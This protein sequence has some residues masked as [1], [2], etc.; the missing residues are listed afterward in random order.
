MAETSGFLPAISEAMRMAERQAEQS[1]M[2]LVRAGKL[3]LSDITPVRTDAPRQ[4]EFRPA[5]VASEP[6]QE[7]VEGGRGTQRMVRFDE[8]S[9]P[10]QEEQRQETPD[11]VPADRGTEMVTNFEKAA[12]REKPASGPEFDI[13]FEEAGSKASAGRPGEKAKK[14]DFNPF[15]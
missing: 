14:K 9:E 1:V 8:S 11:V 4:S 2:D 10:R 7:I 15:D 3:T 12:P 13:A 5:Q 6:Q